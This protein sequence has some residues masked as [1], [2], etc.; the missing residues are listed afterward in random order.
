ML[1]GWKGAFAGSEA[2]TPMLSYA[3]NEIM[4]IFLLMSLILFIFAPV[5]IF[6]IN[7]YEISG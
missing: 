2:R 3:S 6:R 1:K 7:K 4:A 5:S